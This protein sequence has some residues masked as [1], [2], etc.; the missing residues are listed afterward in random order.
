LQARLHSAADGSAGSNNGAHKPPAKTSSN[1]EAVGVASPETAPESTTQK[2]PAEPR[3]D[4]PIVAVNGD[5]DVKTDKKDNELTE[6]ASNF[7]RD[8]KPPQQE[9]SPSGSQDG[10]KTKAVPLDLKP[11]DEQPGEKQ[12]CQDFVPADVQLQASPDQKQTVP[13]ETQAAPVEKQA[14][15]DE[16]QAALDEKQAIPD[17]NPSPGNCVP[18]SSNLPVTNVKPSLATTDGLHK[19]EQ[20]TPHQDQSPGQPP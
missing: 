17:E 20:Q 1:K 10:I 19:P 11:S 18:P 9:N 12:V 5:T 3:V 16:T 8:A 2:P 14:A 13:D 4:T 6:H 7:S 15:P